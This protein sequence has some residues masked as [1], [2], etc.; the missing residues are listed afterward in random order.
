[1]SESSQSTRPGYCYIPACVIVQLK[2]DKGSH[3][4]W[5]E[6][7]VDIK[8]RALKLSQQSLINHNNTDW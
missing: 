2:T 7:Q 3:W 6:K 5:K 4:F 8:Y 1:M